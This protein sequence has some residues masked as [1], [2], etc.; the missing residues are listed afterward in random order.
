MAMPVTCFRDRCSAKAGAPGGAVYVYTNWGSFARHITACEVK[1]HPERWPVCH[2]CHERIESAYRRPDQM[3]RHH[4]GGIGCQAC[5]KLQD[6]M[7]SGVKTNGAL[8]DWL[9]EQGLPICNQFFGKPIAD[10]LRAALKENP[11]GRDEKLAIPLL[12]R[13]GKKAP[14]RRRNV[15]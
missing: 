6:L 1:D 7:H 12:P 13:K 14:R 5:P 11:V 2:F 4:V 3:A 8:A 10:A 9:V 15:E